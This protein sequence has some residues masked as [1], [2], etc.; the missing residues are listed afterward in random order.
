MYL[1]KKNNENF[2]FFTKNYIPWGLIK[3]KPGFLKLLKK[4]IEKSD[5]IDNFNSA[6]DKIIKN[7][8]KA[9]NLDSKIHKTIVFISGKCYPNISRQASYMK[10]N[11]FKT[12][13][14][15]MEN[16]SKKN[17]EM[18]E[19]SFDEI[20]QN[21]SFFPTLGKII[22]SIS[23]CFFHVQCWMWDFSLGKFVIKQRSKSKVICDFYD[24]TGMYANY[25]DLKIVFDEHSIKQ[26]L[27]CEKFIFENSD[28][29][30]HRYKESVFI[31]YAKRYK[32]N[33]K[34]L[35]FQQYADTKL[36]QSNKLT[37]KN[38]KLK[39]VFCG[40]LIPPNDINHPHELF[41]PAGLSYSF[42]KILEGN[43]ELNVFQPLNSNKEFNKWLFD[44]KKNKFSETLKIHNFLPLSE[45]IEKISEYDFGINIQQ[46]DMKKT[47]VS[48]YTFDGAMGTK[49]Y[50]Y[51]EA[52]LPIIVNKEFKYHDEIVT[53]NNIGLSIQSE[54][55]SNFNHLIKNIN[56]N[57]LKENVKKFNLKNSLLIQGKDLLSFYNS[58]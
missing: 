45:L 30:I 18:I 48:K 29:I 22:N 27:S 23:P 13:L 54:D 7:F 9:V 26:D 31:E 51:L 28:G 55:L 39:F 15:T 24:V 2:E 41:S 16:L 46:V 43:H 56:L 53:K 40:T 44:L 11:R 25:D 38:E 33:G 6:S 1:Q 32:N 52:G 21:C 47:R 10:K 19:N 20:L 34:F 50:T 12:Y 35:E 42:N 17:L 14:I 36:S 37:V 57:V 8:V 49:N 3:R 58:L 5:I 4:E